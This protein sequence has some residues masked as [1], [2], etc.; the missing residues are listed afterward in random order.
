MRQIKSSLALAACAS[1]AL[2]AGAMTASAD[3]LLDATYRCEMYSGSTL[4]HLGDIEISGSTY[5]GPANDGNYGD[6]YDYELT[7]AGTINWGGPMGGFD[8]DG[9]TI[10][11]TVLKQ[12]GDRQAFDITMQLKSGNFMTVSCS[13]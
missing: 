10:V 12:N 11:S 1:F 6:A 4:M 7:D 13:S 8:S 5:R 2:V 3:N 9:N